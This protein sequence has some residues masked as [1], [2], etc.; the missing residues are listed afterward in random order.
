MHQRAMVS[1][2][3]FAEGDVPNEAHNK[4][5][6]WVIGGLAVV[7]VIGVMAL[8]KRSAR[9][10]SVEFVPNRA[11]SSKRRMTKSKLVERIAKEQGLEK[12]EVR[13]V[14]A[15]LQDAMVKQI[16]PGGSGEIMIPGVLKVKRVRTKARKA[17]KGTNPFTGEA[18]TFKAKKAGYKVRV[19]ALKSLKDAAKKRRRK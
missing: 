3:G 14:F 6:P 11:R 8:S 17:R 9:T 13:K 5:L 1:F 18:M 19:T 7:G 4:W 2:R 16:A 10:A 12:A 15:G